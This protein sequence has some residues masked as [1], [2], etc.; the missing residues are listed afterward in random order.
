MGSHLTGTL[1]L[2]FLLGDGF[3]DE[4]Y[5]FGATFTSVQQTGAPLLIRTH[6]RSSDTYLDDIDLS[7]FAAT[8]NSTFFLGITSDSAFNRIYFE[9]SDVNDIFRMDDAAFA[10]ST[11]APFLEPST[12]GLLV[13]GVLLLAS[14]RYTRGPETEPSGSTSEKYFRHVQES[15]LPQSMEGGICFRLSGV[16]SPHTA[17]TCPAVSLYRGSAV[18][19]SPAGVSSAR[20]VGQL[21]EVFKTTTLD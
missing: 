20:R 10:T 11:A 19:S 1:L 16:E 7:S 18:R 15:P 3:Y 9:D 5:A 13:T 2:G 17:R 21:D 8:E 14:R 6:E 12:W 4:Y